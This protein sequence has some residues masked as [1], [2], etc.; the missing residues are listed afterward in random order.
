[1]HEKG[2]RGIRIGRGGIR[3]KRR[4]MDK[5]RRE[6]EARVLLIEGAW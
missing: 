6:R 3:I 4:K 1:M 5:K 2:K